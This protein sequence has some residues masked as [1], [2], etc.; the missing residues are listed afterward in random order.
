MIIREAV[1]EDL[2]QLLLLYT[3]LN[4]NTMPEIDVRVENV[5]E[6]ILSEDTLHV[7]VGVEGGII[8]SS[9]VLM[10]IPNLTQ[11]QRPYAFVESVVTHADHRKK[12]YGTM[13]LEYAKQL[14]IREDCYKISLMTGSKLESTHN[15]YRNAG[16]NSGDKTAFIQWL[17]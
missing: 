14:A 1:K 17:Q 5:W 12:G 15:F 6:T 3:H 2:E 13:V 16:Y 4:E 11:G 9:C 7:V 10:I 8:V